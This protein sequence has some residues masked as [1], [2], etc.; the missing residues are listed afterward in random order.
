MSFSTV[1][2][3]MPSTSASPRHSSPPVTSNSLNPSS[4]TSS[5]STSS[6]RSS[7]HNYNIRGIPVSFPYA[8]YPN[9]LLYMDKAIAA[10]EQSQHALLE[11]PTGTGKCFAAGTHLRLADGG[12]IAVENVVGGEQL[13]GDDGL[14]RTVTPGSLARG[15]A[16]L[17][18]ITPTHDG[19]T[20]FTVNGDHILVLT[21]NVKPR[22]KAKSNHRGWRVLE[23]KVNPITNRMYESSFSR[24][25]RNE[26]QARAHL[27]TVM[28]RWRPP[29]WEV[30]VRDFRNSMDEAQRICKLIACKAITFNNPQLPSLQQRLT[31]L[32]N[33]PPTLAQVEYMAWWLGMWVSDGHSGRA[34]VYQGGAPPPDP[35]QH[36]QIFNRLL[37]YQQLFNQPVLRAGGQLSTAG[38]PVYWFNYGV[39]SVADR[40]LRSY[41]LINNK[42]IS[43]ALICDSID[44]RRRCLAGLIDGDGYYSERDNT[45]E[46]HAK[47]RAVIDGYKELAATL[48]LRNGPVAAHACTDQQTGVQ[49]NG[50]RIIIS[51]RMWDAVQYCAATYKQCP[52]PGTAGY[53]QKNKDTHCYGF[54]I[55]RLP[56]G[57]YFGFTVHGGVNQRFLLKDYTVTHNVSRDSLTL[58]LI[59]PHLPIAGMD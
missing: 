27:A 31:A 20:A 55:T 19:A 56:V 18:R 54:T 8:A 52:Q 11:S 3:S 51:G 40:V 43:Q 44:V 24:G 5:S 14:P 33:R 21:N 12:L 1:R 13:M 2:S 10:C 41:G 59:P 7:P 4:S 22:A 49:Y 16:V 9:Q 53:V 42:H 45:Y 15:H 36:Q 25:L 23:W 32:L 17:Y 57:P 48:G 29:E 58:Q 37:T 35:H 30:S 34:S 6:T 46:I 47:H 28:A 38:W 39:G 50:Y 26:A